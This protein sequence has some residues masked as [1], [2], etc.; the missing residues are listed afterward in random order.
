[1]KTLSLRAVQCIAAAEIVGRVEES[2][3]HLHL[4]ASRIGTDFLAAQ[5]PIAAIVTAMTSQASEIVHM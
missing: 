5:S 1:M 4:E 3:M 2:K